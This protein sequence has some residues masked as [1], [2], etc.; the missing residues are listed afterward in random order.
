MKMDNRALEPLMNEIRALCRALPGA[1]EYVMVH[2]PAM[3]VGKKPFFIAGMESAAK[4]EATLSVNLGPMMQ[5]EL[6]DEPRFWRTPYIGQHGWV[7]VRRS[8]VSK[9]ELQR[10]VEESWRR[11]AGKKQLAARDA[12]VPAASSKPAVKSPAK[13]GASK[14][15]PAKARAP[16]KVSAKKASARKATTG[17]TRTSSRAR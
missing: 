13:A 12:G 16:K 17:G 5:G 15:P 14:T 3:R 7:T 2:H 6:L 8:G 10:L 4:S 1:E 9:Q 11:I